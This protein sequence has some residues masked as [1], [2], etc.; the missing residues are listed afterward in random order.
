MTAEKNNDVD[1]FIYSHKAFQP[2]VTD[3]VFKVLTCAKNEAKEFNTDLE[4]FRDYTLNNIS[5][6]NL[7]YN[8]YCGFYWL[9]KNYPLKKYVGL[10]H[11]RRYYNCCNNLPDIN[12]ILEHKKLILNKPIPLE[13]NGQKYTN[14]EWYEFW[15]N[16]EDFDLLGE[17]INEYYPQYANGFDK[18]SK[19]PY[20]Y[21]CS[22]FTMPKD[23]F[24]EYC[25]YIFDILNKFRKERCF[26]SSDDCIKY[27]TEHKDKYIKPGLDYYNI[28][29]QARIVGYI[30]ERALGAFLFSGGNNSLEKNAE[31]FDWSMV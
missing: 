20:L 6:K 23:L 1:I 28:Q 21:G 29:M 16:V 4:I 31:I 19:T 15:H 7:M 24:V 8:E 2:I 3:H 11:Y 25:E 30:A 22:M 17:I 27:V 13:R 9:W 10:N 18:M 26:Y 12:A 14:R 5:D